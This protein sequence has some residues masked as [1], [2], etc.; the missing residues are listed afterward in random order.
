MK[1]IYDKKF[2]MTENLHDRNFLDF[3]DESFHDVTIAPIYEKLLCCKP[4]GAHSTRGARGRYRAPSLCKVS[5]C[6]DY[7]N[8][9]VTGDNCRWK[10]FGHGI[11]FFLGYDPF[12]QNLRLNWVRHIT[13]ALIL[14]Q[15]VTGRQEMTMTDVISLLSS[16]D[17]KGSDNELKEIIFKSI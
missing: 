16:E 7:I 15:K 13:S 14:S 3:V 5:L 2:S 6:G 9:D 4:Y 12:L 17:R 1:K 11:R 8:M 10:Q